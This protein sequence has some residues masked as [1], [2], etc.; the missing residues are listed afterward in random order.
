MTK[1]DVELPESSKSVIFLPYCR[2]S[3]AVEGGVHVSSSVR[4][5]GGTL[6]GCSSNKQ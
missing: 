3:I 2:S 6:V 1:Q 4:D 5:E